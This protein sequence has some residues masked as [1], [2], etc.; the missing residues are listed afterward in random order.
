MHDSPVSSPRPEVHEF[1][2][3]RQATAT[4]EAN[5]HDFAFHWTEG[6]ALPLH[7]GTV[8]KGLAYPHLR[9][10]RWGSRGVGASR[11]APNTLNV[12]HIGLSLRVLASVEQEFEQSVTLPAQPLDFD[13]PRLCTSCFACP[14]AVG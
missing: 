10:M 4:I 3:P 13:G 11:A 9:S 12:A 8:G 1:S 14:T 5:P 2:I 7:S 6:V